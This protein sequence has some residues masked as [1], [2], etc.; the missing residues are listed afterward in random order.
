MTQRFRHNATG[1]EV[2]RKP[3]SRWHSTEGSHAMGIRT[4]CRPC[5]RWQAVSQHMLQVTECCTN[6]AG[7]GR[8]LEA[9]YLR[10]LVSVRGEQETH[11]SAQASKCCA[12]GPAGGIPG[13]AFAQHPVGKQ[14]S[15]RWCPPK[16]RKQAGLSHSAVAHH[17][18][19][20]SCRQTLAW[21]VAVLH[22]LL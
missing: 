6:H 2:L 1:A 11:N 18:A 17:R 20:Q 12:A 15:V 14:L 4:P 10:L 16:H 21:D 8:Q 7:N 3:C 13:V 9:Y 5:Y 19:L 22:V